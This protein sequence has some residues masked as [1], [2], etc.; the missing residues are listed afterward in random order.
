MIMKLVWH[1]LA[2]KELLSIGQKV[3]EMFGK[4]VADKVIKGII[5]NI[6]SLSKYPYL[7]TADLRYKPFLVLH[8]KHNRIFYHVSDNEIKIIAIWDNRRDDALLHEMLETRI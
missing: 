5:Q 1:D 6:S 8:S 7:G 4:N 2:Y 3:S